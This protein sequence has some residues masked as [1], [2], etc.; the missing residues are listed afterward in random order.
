[1]TG[2]PPRIAPC[3]CGSGRRFKHCHGAIGAAHPSLPDFNL[4]GRRLE[5]QRVQREQQQGKG[6][7]FITG[8]VGDQRFVVVGNTITWGKWKTVPDFLMHYMSN[9]FGSDWGNAELAKPHDQRHPLLNQYQHLCGIQ[10]SGRRGEDGLF[11]SDM[12]GGIASYFG[13]AYSLYYLEHNA[14]VHERLL[15]RLRNKDLFEDTRY[16]ILIAGAFARA[17][18]SLTYEDEDDGTTTHV[19][20]VA[21]HNT[22]GRSFSIECKRRNSEDATNLK[23]LGRRVR[24]A[25][26]KRADH[27]RIVFV[28]VN[29]PEITLSEDE[30]PD[31]LT[32]AVNQVH[33]LQDKQQGVALPPACVILTNNPCDL[34]PDDTHIGM[35][36][37]RTAINIHEMRFDRITDMRGQI[38]E[39]E[40]NREIY[41][42]MESLRH[43]HKIPSTFDGSIAQLTFGH[44]PPRLLVGESYQLDDGTVGTIIEPPV[45][46]EMEKKAFCLLQ[47]DDGSQ[48]Y[49]NFPM[50]D[51]EISGWRD[52]PTTF[53][54]VVQDYNKPLKKPL[55]Y[56]DFHLKTL[57]SMSKEQ[58]LDILQ[59]WPAHFEL[60][61]KSRDQL[62]SIL[63]EN[64]ALQML[65]MTRERPPS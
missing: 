61:S 28:D 32:K 1:M 20:F 18:Y 16:E 21:T 54:G 39:R 26:K 37:L 33:N 15:H 27:E 24:K 4:I 29:Y 55:D 53:F 10:A 44:A 34:F 8:V 49:A 56:Y 46:M 50:S 30:M 31:W 52:H 64:R 6:K 40:S 2:V 60:P 14:E 57:E 42:L 17:G 58:L 25:L 9:I 41:E 23:R 22:T 47:L 36:A 7:G 63:A 59:G 11:K 62:A 65:A 51:S 5:A 13:L 45:V 43:H 48:I 3:P 38:D 35:V 19:E 12:T